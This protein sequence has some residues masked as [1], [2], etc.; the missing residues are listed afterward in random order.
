M[1]TQSASPADLN[2]ALFLNLIAMLSISALQQLG[3]IINPMTGKTEIS[4]EGAQATI[5]MLDML[6]AKTRG[7]RDAEEDKTLKDTLTMLKMNYVETGSAKPG[8]DQKQA[9]QKSEISDQPPDNK[10]QEP[11]A[12]GA[13]TSES[14][15]PKFHKTYS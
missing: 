1:P 5:D 2:K 4:L 14:K 7:N 12:P 8:E 15:D 9:S 11:A 13:D 10:P 3:K 6:E